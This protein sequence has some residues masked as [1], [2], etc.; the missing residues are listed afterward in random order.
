MQQGRFLTY[1]S[2]N[3]R[4]KT[5]NRTFHHHH[6]R[7]FVASLRPKPGNLIYFPS[8]CVPTTQ[9]KLH[10]HIRMKVT[11]LITGLSRA[12]KWKERAHSLT[13][14]LKNP[15]ETKLIYRRPIITGGNKLVCTLADNETHVLNNYCCKRS[16]VVAASYSFTKVRFVRGNNAGILIVSLVEAQGFRVFVLCIWR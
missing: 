3:L 9:L 11:A 10:S 4:R 8:T 16:R 1:L 2:L 7:L 14:T 12:K 6:H 13:Q 15:I 5:I